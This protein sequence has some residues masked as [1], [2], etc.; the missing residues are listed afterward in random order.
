MLIDVLLLFL[1]LV[2]FFIALY[3]TLVYY[4]K[5]SANYFL[6]PRICRMD[7]STCQSVLWTPEARVLG[8]PNFVL[9]LIYYLLVFCTALF[10]LFCPGS[11]Y[12]DFL[13]WTSIA[14]VIVGIYLV[15]SLLFR[16][17]ISCPLCFTS[18]GINL[19]IALLLLLK[20]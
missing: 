8:A 7:E 5:I 4:N 14:A 1:S 13:L 16:I 6:V 2:G 11:I 15:Y 10:Q 19:V 20:S 12:H 18:H 3:F 9:G 17:K